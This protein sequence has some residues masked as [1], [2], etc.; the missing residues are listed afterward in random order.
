[1]RID[2][3]AHIL[4]G[5][6]A[7]VTG[8]VALYAVKGATLHRKSGMVFVYAMLT[9]SVFGAGMAAARGVAPKANVPVGLLTAYLVITA[10]I[11]V[12]PPAGWS[13]RLDI[14]LMLVAL[15][16]GLTDLLF[17]FKSFAS[18]AFS[19]FIGQARVIPKPIRI[20][21]LLALPALAV[22]VTMLYWLWRVRIRRTFRGMVGVGAAEAVLR[23]HGLDEPSRTAGLRIAAS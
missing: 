18:A 14:G 13:R 21:P 12:R 9:M 1:M 3:V 19:F 10:L 16:I 7:V 5:T 6:L 23:T 22:L 2:L 15:A 8:F 17:G 11:T 20:F 4:A